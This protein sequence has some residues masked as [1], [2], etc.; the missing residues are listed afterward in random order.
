MSQHGEEEVDD[1][2][3]DD[4]QP[5]ELSTPSCKSVY[6]FSFSLGR[7]FKE[8]KVIHVLSTEKDKDSFMEV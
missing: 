7:G 4:Q 8:H 1:V 6:G 5:S 2:N 3:M